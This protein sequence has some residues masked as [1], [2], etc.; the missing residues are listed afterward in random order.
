MPTAMPDLVRRQM[1]TQATMN[2]YRKCVWDWKAGVTCI[3][4]ARFHL[5]KMGH[6]PAPMPRVRSLVGAM[7]ALAERECETVAQL[8]DTQPGLVRINPAQM[9]LGDLAVVPGTEG[10]GAVLICAGPQKLIGWHEDAQGMEVLSVR[11]DHLLGA[12]RA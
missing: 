9:L 11:L 2:K 3:H 8:L 7:R 6:R 10:L 1:A 4:M 12:W 5:R